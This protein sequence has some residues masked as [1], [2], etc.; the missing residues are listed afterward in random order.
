MMYDLPKSLDV[1]GVEYAIETDFRAILDIFSI[2]IDEDLDAE[3]KGIGV[4]G[5]FY[6][7]FRDMPVAHI[8]EALK[9][10]FW[11]INSGHEEEQKKTPKLMDWEQDF[12]YIVAPINHIAGQEVRALPYLHWWTFLSYYGEIGDCYF[13]QIVRI[14]D[15][16]AKGKLKDKADREFYRRNRDAIDIKRRYS[17]AEEEIIKGWT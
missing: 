9:K 13:A 17:E 3:A 15:L 4:L 14:R 5:I 10:C 2:L 8:P 16:K 12:Q 1:C 6:F 7:D 11:F